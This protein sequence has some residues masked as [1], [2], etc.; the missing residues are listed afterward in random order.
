VQIS[1]KEEPVSSFKEK[2]EKLLDRKEES[3]AHNTDENSNKS[4]TLEKRLF[5]AHL[6]T[7]E[8]KFLHKEKL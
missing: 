8:K 1:P 6:Q 3:C 4:L 5:N 7:K 2:F